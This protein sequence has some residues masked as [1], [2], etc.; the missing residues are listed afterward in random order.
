M[1]RSD[2]NLVVQ[3]GRVTKTRLEREAEL[4]GVEPSALVRAILHQHFADVGDELLGWLT[5]AG[6]VVQIVRPPQVELVVPVR[7]T[8]RR[9]RGRP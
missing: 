8:S 5:D 4:R 3:V 6:A 7:Q 9:C 1:K 2:V